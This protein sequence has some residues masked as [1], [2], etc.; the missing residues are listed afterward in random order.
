M[1]EEGQEVC[2][3][4]TEERIPAY[5][6]VWKETPESAIHSVLTRRSTHG[7]EGLRQCSLVPPPRPGR[8]LAGW[9]GRGPERREQGSSSGEHGR[10]PRLRTRR[11]RRDSLRSVRGGRDGYHKG[12]G[13]GQVCGRDGLSLRGGRGGRPRGLRDSRDSLRGV[14]GGHESAP[15]AGEVGLHLQRLLQG[16]R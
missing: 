11:G 13:G 12:G 14:R 2:V 5:G 16:R 9:S 3:G 15:A 7:A 10:R 6:V 4:R 1:M 8:L